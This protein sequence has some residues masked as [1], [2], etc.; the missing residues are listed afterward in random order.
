MNAANSIPVDSTGWREVE[1][2]KD[3]RLNLICLM[4]CCA[5]I[6]HL[7]MKSSV[8]MGKLLQDYVGSQPLNLVLTEIEL[9]H[10]HTESN[11]S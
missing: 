10:V 2:G 9:S 11:T 1:I 6:S 4:H 5:Y 7:F 3:R 8:Y